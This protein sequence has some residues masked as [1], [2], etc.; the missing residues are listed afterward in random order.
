MK[1]YGLM[2]SVLDVD[3]VCHKLLSNVILRLTSKSC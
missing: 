3:Q 2:G 1:S